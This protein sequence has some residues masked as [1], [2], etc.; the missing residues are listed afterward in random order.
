M[1]EHVSFV[2]DGLRL[3][4]VLHVPGRRE[5]HERRPAFVVLHGFGSNKKALPRT[6]DTI[7]I[8][9]PGERGHR[10]LERRRRDDIPLPHAI[11]EELARVADRLGVEI[12]A[13]GRSR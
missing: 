10:T 6:A 2:S 8:L 12:F 13:T 3:A 5:P 9:V 4:A 11:V 7:E 1:E